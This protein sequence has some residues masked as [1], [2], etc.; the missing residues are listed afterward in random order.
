MNTEQFYEGPGASPL[1]TYVLEI[2]VILLVA[3]ILGYL[4]RLLLN[5]GVKDK[6]SELEHENSMLKSRTLN[7][8]VSE[9]P[10]AEKPQTDTA[11]LDTKIKQ[12]A[13]I[14]QDLNDRLSECYAK[15]VAAENKLSQLQVKLESA[16]PES[17]AVKVEEAPIVASAPAEASPISNAK[18]SL[19][20]IEGIGPKIEQ[21]LHDGG[22]LTFSDL[23]NAKVERLKEILIAAGPNYAVHDPST[24]GEQS[25]LAEAGKWDELAQLQDELKGGKR[26]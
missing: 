9:K 5:D 7:A 6:I 2:A 23:K 10:V 24:W 16:K 12:Q 18:D 15:R 21:L 22:V 11:E 25:A 17:P 19:R 4:L 8:K 26:K 1:T 3:F 14:I 20:K 13:R